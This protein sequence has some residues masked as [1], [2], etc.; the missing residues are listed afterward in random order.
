MTDRE[1]IIAD[2]ATILFRKDTL[3]AIA[4]LDQ[5][6]CAEFINACLDY[7][8]NGVIKADFQNETARALFT[9]AMPQLDEAMEQ[10]ITGRQQRIDAARKRHKD[11]H[12]E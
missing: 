9:L 4:S 2:K 8:N 10:Y 12:D 3:S 11:K 5:G 7:D 1:R 6:A